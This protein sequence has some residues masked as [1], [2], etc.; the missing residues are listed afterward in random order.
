MD[1]RGR[2][3]KMKTIIIKVEDIVANPNNP[4]VITDL[5][6]EKLK[7]SINDFPEM[8][9]L[10]PIVVNE[11]NMVLG[12]NMRLKAIK[13]LGV[14]EVAVIKSSGLTEEQVKE[15]IVKDNSNFGDWDFEELISQYELSNLDD[16]G[17]DV[18]NSEIKIEG[19]AQFKQEEV[20]FSEYTIY[21]ED[22]EEQ[23]IFFRFL[24][25]IKNKFDGVENVSERVIRYIKSV[26]D[27]NNMS[28]S[29]A[30]LKFLESDKEI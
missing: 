10:R 22:E 17:V 24:A 16:Y 1:K 5:Q 13:E 12:G 18:P 14:E 27:E 25:H 26:Y 11:E 2:Q 15:F 7:K 3:N 4:R 29:K 23:E 30:I 8:M 21:F 28:E 19:E 9:N 20:D 6:F